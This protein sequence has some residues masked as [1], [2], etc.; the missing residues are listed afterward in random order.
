MLTAILAIFLFVIMIFPH[1][2][3]HFIV[4]KAV[5]VKVNE[6][7]FGMGPAIWKKQKGETLYAIRIFPIGGYC[8]MEGEN[9]DSDHERAFNN[10]SGKAKIAVL[11]AG[12]VMNVLIAILVMIILMGVIGS[13]TTTID[14]V[15]SGSPAYTAGIQAGDT[16]MAVDSTKVEKWNDLSTLISKNTKGMT[17]TVDRNGVTKDLKVI[18][19]KSDGR[20]IVGVTPAVSHNAFTA[21]KNGLISTWNMTKTMFVALQ[22]LFSGQV[23]VKN[24]SGPVGIVSLVH[25]SES[26]GLYSFFYLLAFI[27]INLAVINLLPLPA[28]DGGRII[29]VIIRA[30]TGKKITDKMEASV[31]AA[32]MILLLGLMVF[33]TWNDIVRLFQ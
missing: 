5:G 4:A 18:P 7:A 2:L 25:Q 15:Q 13:P 16:I 1:E 8:A 24:L 29:F 12:S 31:H 6:F 19:V 28:L 21:V 3:G 9:E 23:A 30:I 10:K 33:V 17:I 32:G 27:S 14:K 22:Q 26:Y 11:L 20:Y